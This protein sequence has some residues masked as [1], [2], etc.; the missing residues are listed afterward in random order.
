MSTGQSA[1]MLCG[2]GVKAGWF[3]AF[4]LRRSRGEMYTGHA[5]LCVCPSPHLAF[6]HYCTD[7]DVTWGNGRGCCLVVYCW[8]DLES[9]H[10]LHCDNNMASAS[11]CTRCMPGSTV[12]LCDPSLVCV[13]PDRFS[14]ELLRILLLRILLYRCLYFF[15]F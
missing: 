2:W 4:R 7:P 9:L 8:A 5:R 3:I 10:G 1:V 12:N 14:G 15:Y 13:M 6:P 11:A